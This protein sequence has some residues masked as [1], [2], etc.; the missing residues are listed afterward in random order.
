MIPNA[1]GGI[2]AKL[3][4]GA[5]WGIRIDAEPNVSLILPAV[6]GLIHIL[7]DLRGKG[8]VSGSV[9][10]SPVAILHALIESRISKGNGGISAVQQTVN[11]FALLSLAR[12]A[13]LPEN[14][15]RI[16]QRA[17]Q[18][19]VAAHQCPIARSAFHQNLQKAFMSPPPETGPHPP[20]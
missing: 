3:V 9:W 6:A 12:G 13:V 1:S 14:G 10:D 4:G 8:V 18:T 11:G 20:G 15:R 19:V 7:H 17:S 5:L 2:L 16:G